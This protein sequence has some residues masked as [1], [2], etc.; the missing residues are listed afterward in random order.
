M[1]VGLAS[2]PGGS[3][4]SDASKQDYFGQGYFSR[5]TGGAASL[6]RTPS[7]LWFRLEGVRL[8]PTLANR[9]TSDRAIFRVITGGTPPA[10]GQ[11]GGGISTG[12]T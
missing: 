12:A 4:G 11:P 6:R 3:T 1:F 10:E 5:C 2:T 8:D 7:N 9:A